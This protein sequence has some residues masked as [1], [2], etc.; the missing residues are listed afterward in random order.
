MAQPQAQQKPKYTQE[1][2]KELIKQQTDRRN[3]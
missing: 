1:Q 3:G 2:L